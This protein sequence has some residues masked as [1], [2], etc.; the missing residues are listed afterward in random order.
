MQSKQM[1]QNTISSF[2]PRNHFRCLLSRSRKRHEEADNFKTEK[3][4]P[5]IPNCMEL[6][7]PG[8]L[9]SHGVAKSRTGLSNFIFTF[10]F[11]ALEK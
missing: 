2:C 11:H 8:G 9:Q 6:E 1:T 10:H 4:W 3:D 7:E 5:L